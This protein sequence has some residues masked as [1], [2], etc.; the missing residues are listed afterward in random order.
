M[1]NYKN[2]KIFIKFLHLDPIILEVEPT[3]EILDVKRKI[4]D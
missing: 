4:E 1:Y 2:M 3:D